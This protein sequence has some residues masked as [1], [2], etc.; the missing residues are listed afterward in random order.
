MKCLLNRGY[1]VLTA[2][3]PKRKTYFAVAPRTGLPDSVAAIAIGTFVFS[4]GVCVGGGVNVTESGPLWP[5]SAV[6][7][8]A[9]AG[10]S[11]SAATAASTPPL[12]ATAI[13]R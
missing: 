5:C 1:W 7:A 2:I 13:P 4:F 11:A 9:A 3:P 12:R 6:V 10:T 8:T